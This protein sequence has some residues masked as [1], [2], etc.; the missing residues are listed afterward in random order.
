[1]LKNQLIASI[2]I[3]RGRSRKRWLDG[4]VHLYLSPARMLVALGSSKRRHSRNQPDPK[5]QDRGKS[6]CSNGLWVIHE[7]PRGV[8]GQ[9]LDHSETAKANVPVSKGNART[10]SKHGRQRPRHGR[11]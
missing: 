9:A 11:T 10:G 1:M 5:N 3:L 6:L 2:M 4:G 7:L 8:A